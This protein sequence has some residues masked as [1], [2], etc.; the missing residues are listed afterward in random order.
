[1]VPTK[2]SIKFCANLRKSATEILAMIRYAFGEES[3]SHA[4]KV[5][6]HQECDFAMDSTKEQHLIM[7]RSP[8]KCARDPGSD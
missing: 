6:T 1:V 7:C 8:K 2:N 5:Q 3:M 4:R